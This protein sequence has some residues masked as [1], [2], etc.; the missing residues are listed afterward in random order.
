M[1]VREIAADRT[2]S[3]RLEGSGPRFSIHPVD[4][5]FQRAK[6]LAQSMG[7]SK[8]EMLSLLGVPG[9]AHLKASL[10]QLGLGRMPDDEA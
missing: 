1:W 7:F 8:H 2:I 9:T 4:F 10:A 6:R 5:A 3:W